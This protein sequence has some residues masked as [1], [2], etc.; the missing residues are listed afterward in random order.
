MDIFGVFKKKTDQ[1]GAKLPY[2]VMTE[3]MPYRLYANQ[4]GSASLM[5]KIKNVTNDTLLSSVSVEL[6][7][8]LGFDPTSMSKLKEVKLGNIAPNEQK[9]LHFD[10]YNSV[11]ADKGKYSVDLTVMSHYRDY[12][13]IIDSVKKPSPIE[14]V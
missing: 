2:L 7:K 4:K 13:H 9:E 6:P 5:V 8:N 14:V 11:G 12:G 10:V 3:W 1:A